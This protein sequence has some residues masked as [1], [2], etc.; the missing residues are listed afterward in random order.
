MQKV[1]GYGFLGVFLS[2]LL[3]V[4]TSLLVLSELVALPEREKAYVVGVPA[5]NDSSTAAYQGVHPRFRERPAETFQFPIQLNQVGPSVPL[6]AGDNR[7]PFL[8]GKEKVH[9]AQPLIDNHEQLGVP[10]YALDETGRQTD[11]VLGYSKDCLHATKARYYYNRVGT[12]KFYPLDEANNDIAKVMVNGRE[13]DF[14]VR[15]EIGT[16]NR[17][18]YG[19]AAIK[20]EDDIARPG[21]ENWNKRLVYQFRGGVGIGRRQGKISH[22]DLL[23]RRYDAISRGYAVVYS[24]ANQTSNHYNIWLSEDTAL[25][26]KKQFAALYGEPDYTVGIGGSGGAIQQYLFAQ[27]NPDVIDAAIALYAYPDM[28]TQT[29]YVMDCE[30][31]EYYFD[32]T[33][34][35]NPRWQS[36]DSRS[37]VQGL[38]AEAEVVSRFSYLSTVA[39]LLQGKWPGSLKGASECVAGWRGLTPL[40]HNPN[41]IHYHNQF[42]KHI[43]DQEHWTHWDDLKKF[44]GVDSHGYANSTWDNVGVQY[45]LQALQ[46]GKISIDEFLHLNANIGGWKPFHEMDN[47][48]Y[49][50]MQKKVFPVDFSEWSHHN[51]RLSE[52]NGYTPA[53]R[54]AGSLEAMQGAYRSGHV[55][56]GHADIPIID[57]RHYLEDELDMHHSTASFASRIRMQ[58]GQGH[59]DNQLI[60]MAAKPYIPIPEALEVLDQWLLN[61]QSQP[62]KSFVAS[63]PDAA[64]DKCFDDNGDI[65]ASG[66]HV[67]DGDWNGRD[68]GS[69]MAVYP[70]YKTTR[71]VAGEGLAGDIFKCQLQPLQQALDSGLYGDVNVRPYLQRLQQI[72]P[73]G[74]CDYSKPDLGLP[75]QGWFKEAEVSVAAAAPVERPP[76]LDEVKQDEQEV[77][78][79]SLFEQP[80]G[81]QS[82]QLH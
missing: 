57:L 8:C 7:Y 40:V 42:R 37:A 79:L 59:A 28:V 77:L 16:I 65:I 78:T 69:C 5:V 19:I 24:T 66:E 74:V 31:L 64:V 63:K 41:F 9:K 58:K 50:L 56:V 22:N 82:K 15:L 44:Y 2:L 29:T 6:F 46:A 47:E 61:K 1:I 48:K 54:T 36:W 39:E 4:T 67:W 34:R 20:A 81:H 71:E 10:V 23:N 45:G 11:E 80:G 76:A 35:Q 18:F 13:V 73:Q 62:D 53:P 43:V 55:F 30:P 68:T 70:R 3:I 17:F 75:E 26:L 52:N 21:P 49:W 27:N 32:V 14:I 12:D 33:A 25:R 51:M 72:F 60:W 38:N